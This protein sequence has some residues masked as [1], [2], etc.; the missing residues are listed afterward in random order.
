MPGGEYFPQTQQ[1]FL[2]PVKQC[3]FRLAAQSMFIPWY[4]GIQGRWPL[5]HSYQV[6]APSM[7][8]WM[9][10]KCSS[11][12]CSSLIQIGIK[13]Q[14]GLLSVTCYFERIVS[15]RRCQSAADVK[16]VFKP[17]C[18]KQSTLTETTGK[19]HVSFSSSLSFRSILQSIGNSTLNLSFL[20]IMTTISW[21]LTFLLHVKTKI[22]VNFQLRSIFVP[23]KTTGFAD[24][25]F[26][27]WCQNDDFILK[28]TFPALWRVRYLW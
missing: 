13:G 5:S 10:H 3:F 25:P 19:A 24:L 17:L 9:Q 4:C 8:Q 7:G 23:D 18:H 21:F 12:W 6:R 20:F 27:V 28:C 1:Q 26:I 16:T 2:I 22:T 11:G 14:G 15:S